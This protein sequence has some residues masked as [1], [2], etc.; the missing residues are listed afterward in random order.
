MW[1]F[2]IF[3]TFFQNIFE[4][5]ISAAS[6]KLLVQSPENFLCVIWNLDTKK[7]SKI[8]KVTIIFQNV[9]KKIEKIVMDSKKSIDSFE[10]KKWLITSLFRT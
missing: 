7:I 9:E 1:I 8:R 3:F 10:M 4:K 6:V 2:S 5:K